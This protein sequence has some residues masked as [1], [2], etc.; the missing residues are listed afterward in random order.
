M[1]SFEKYLK[2]IKKERKDLGLSPKPID[3]ANI[4]ND[5]IYYIKGPDCPNRKLSIDFFIYNVLPG[6]TNAANVKANFLKDIILDKYTI[7]EISD[8]LAF[9]LLSHM[10]GGPSIKVLI[11]LALGQNKA[12]SKS[13]KCFK[14]SSVFI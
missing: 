10:K 4:I 12:I 11:D 9:E 14:N 8:D 6:T 3:D 5:I 13:G 2:Q 1:K 7:S